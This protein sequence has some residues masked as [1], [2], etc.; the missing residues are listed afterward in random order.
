MAALLAGCHSL[1]GNEVE[2]ANLLVAGEHPD[3]TVGRDVHR[4]ALTRQEAVERLAVEAGQA[5]AVDRQLWSTPTARF[6]LTSA[7][8]AVF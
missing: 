8:S 4:D 1:R 3:R 6:D 7:C 5:V 2:V